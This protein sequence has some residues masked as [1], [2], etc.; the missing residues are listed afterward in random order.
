MFVCLTL[1][2]PKAE[3]RE[4]REFERRMSVF[5]SV[6]RDAIRNFLQYCAEHAGLAEG[7]HALHRFWNRIP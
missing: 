3:G 4:R 6:Q 1:T 2:P 7:R 5:N